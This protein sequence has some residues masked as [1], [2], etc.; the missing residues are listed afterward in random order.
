MFRVL[1]GLPWPVMA[2]IAAG[3]FWLAQQSGQWVAEHEA[4]KAEAL[5]IGAPEPV[6]LDAF[7]A[8]DVG[9]ADEVHVTAWVNTEHNYEL[10]REGKTVD[11]VRR[12][13]VLFGPGDGPEST[14]ARGVVVL[15]PDKVDDFVAY[16]MLNLTEEN[17]PRLLFNLNGSRESRADLSG[18][19]DNALRERGLEKDA[20]FLVVQPYL[21]GRE[22]ALAA[23]PDA[24]T[25]NMKIIGG[26]GLFVAL[27]AVLKFVAARRRA[28]KANGSVW[29]DETPRGG[30]VV[31]DIDARTGETLAET[32]GGADQAKVA[33]PASGEW[34]PL[35]AV[36]AKQAAREAV[37]TGP[38]RND[39]FESFSGMA[40]GSSGTGLGLSLPKREGAGIGQMFR[41][42]V[43]V[44]GSV[45]LYFLIYLVF[46]G[47]T[48]PT[49]MNTVSEDGMMAAVMEGVSGLDVSE[50]EAEV[51]QGVAAFTDETAQVA[52]VTP[53]QEDAPAVAPPLSP[54]SAE[55]AEAVSAEEPLVVADVGTQWLEDMQAQI[56]WALAGAGLLILGAGG[57]MLSRRGAKPRGPDP[58]DRLGERL[59]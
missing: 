30:A 51:P 44:L 52:P 39:G 45:G 36:R 24:P 10:T 19:V 17:D 53:V 54:A 33:S 49:T 8:A 5:L 23:D 18:M 21:E 28:R 31:P 3:L 27:L 20:D 55:T 4:E 25:R 40:G 22:V 46:G 9:L 15:H 56:I 2:V 16:L 14:V 50:L 1:F 41:L 48:L 43:A 59:R 58:Y 13:F 32:E 12:M 57:I 7:T 34:S 42:P 47:L 38:K 29:A 37:G 26:A 35:E 6:A 11:T